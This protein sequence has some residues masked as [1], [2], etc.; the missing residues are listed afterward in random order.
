MRAMPD[1]HG[2]TV[3][4]SDAANIREAPRGPV[5]FAGCLVV[6]AVVLAYLEV[7]IEGA[8][9]WATAL[10]TW[11]TTDPRITWIFAGRPVTGYHV[12]LNLLL[13]AWL[14]W[15]ALFGRWSVV[16]EARVLSSYAL[17]A[18]IWDFLWFVLNPHFGLSRY[19]A[20]H[21]WWFRHWI[22]GVPRDYLIGLGL[23]LLLWS[24]PALVRR[25]DRR[26]TLIDA[27][28]FVGTALALVAAVTVVR[29]IAG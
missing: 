23:A 11:R 21:V 5:A 3:S 2:T 15:P 8:N 1:E 18:V 13:L 14:H 16:H 7:Q 17:L 9:G 6:I 27:L 25:A 19:D 10:P 28:V 4:G 26:R 22:L 12:A 24:A 29:V 20:A